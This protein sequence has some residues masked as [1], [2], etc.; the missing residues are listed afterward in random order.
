L[1]NNKY[2]AL[3]EIPKIKLT[4]FNQ[5]NSIL[6]EPHILKKL[7]DFKFITKIISSFQDFD[8][9]YLVTNL[10][11]GDILHNYKDDKMSE[12]EIKFIIACIIQS[13]E[14]LREKQ[15]INRDV[16][17]KNLILDE[18]KYLNLI[19]FSFAIKYSDKNNANNIIVGN[20]NESA[21]EMLNHQEYDYNSDYYR[22]GTILYYLIFKNYINDVKKRS[23][24]NEFVIDFKNIS[25][26]SS[27][28]ID[29]LNKLII[30][31]YKKRIGFHDI[32]NFYF[33]NRRKKHF[34]ENFINHSTY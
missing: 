15:I 13:L 5:I 6:N 8:N 9:L 33:E 7:I 12:K 4:T 26:Y 21:P 17:M 19:D 22:I 2:Y 11:E 27:N 34:I 32:D 29:F 18:K 1:L 3:K 31:D 23:N 24:L 16:R 20:K 14:Y 10:Y 30:I 25:N 28:C